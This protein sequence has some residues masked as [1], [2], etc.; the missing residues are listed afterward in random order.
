MANAKG[1]RRRFGALRQLPSGQWQY[2][3]EAQMA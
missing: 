2:A 3:T 1:R